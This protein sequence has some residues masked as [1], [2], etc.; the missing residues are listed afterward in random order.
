MKTKVD[1]YSTTAPDGET[2]YVEKFT[3]TRKLSSGRVYTSSFEGRPT[4]TM[5]TNRVI[6]RV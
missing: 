2:T 1:V 5:Y 6:R 3:M 4:K